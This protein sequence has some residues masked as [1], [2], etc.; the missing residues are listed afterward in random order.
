MRL[1]DCIKC[2]SGYFGASIGAVLG[3]AEIAAIGTVA[4]V[5]IDEASD[6]APEHGPEQEKEHP[7][8]GCHVSSYRQY[9]MFGA[10]PSAGWQVSLNHLL[11]GAFN[12]RQY[13]QQVDS[14]FARG[15]IS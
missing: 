3:P 1:K 10:K 9:G 12:C 4:S 15:L 13:G 14:C 7:F 8:G 2:W 11:M 5:Q 6:P